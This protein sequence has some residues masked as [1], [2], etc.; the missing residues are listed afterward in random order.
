MGLMGL[1]GLISVIGGLLFLVV[2]FLSIRGRDRSQ[3]CRS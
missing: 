2:C 3:P 1:G